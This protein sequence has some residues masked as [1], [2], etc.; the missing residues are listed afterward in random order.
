MLLAPSSSVM[1]VCLKSS[2][3]AACQ[4]EM[5]AELGEP[6]TVLTVLEPQHYQLPETHAT[7]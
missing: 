2:V 1:E 3:L 5:D 6:Q 4:S 7:K